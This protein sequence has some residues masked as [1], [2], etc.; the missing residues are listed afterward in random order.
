MSSFMVTRACCSMTSRTTP[1]KYASRRCSAA[2]SASVRTV[3]TLPQKRSSRE[4]QPC[5]F[6]DCCHTTLRRS[7]SP[8][9]VAQWASSQQECTV[10]P[11]TI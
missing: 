6:S 11:R 2:S 3:M 10:G 4:P 5:W 1:D 8:M 7:S 9:F